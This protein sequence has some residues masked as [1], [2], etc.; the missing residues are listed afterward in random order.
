MIPISPATRIFAVTGPT[1][2]RK[3]FDG[4]YGIVANRL[5]QDP[6]TGH[7]FVFCNTARNRIKLLLWDG[8]GLWVCTK[9]LESGRFFWQ[10]DD[11]QSSVT[12]S[13]EQL[14]M[15]LGG[16]DLQQAKPRRWFRKDQINKQAFL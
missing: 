4:L 13:W 9:R 3:S 14:T 7:I 10:W 1:D 6:T 2:M 16:I 8:S 5:A 15:L 12:L 11:A